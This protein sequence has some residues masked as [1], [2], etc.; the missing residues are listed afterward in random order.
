MRMCAQCVCVAMD[1][2]ICVSIDP[3]SMYA[4]G[5]ATDVALAQALLLRSS[6]IPEA[7]EA[8]VG[9][10]E[11]CKTMLFVACSP[12]SGI[13][14]ERARA[15]VSDM[16]DSAGRDHRHACSLPSWSYWVESRGLTAPRQASRL[17]LFASRC[18]DVGG[19]R[20]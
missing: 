16:S 1:A 7:L 2:W 15:S 5:A 20:G 11:P 17:C 6:R 19:R 9:F 3:G 8:P 18:K 10:L 12:A 14:L 4:L 13:A